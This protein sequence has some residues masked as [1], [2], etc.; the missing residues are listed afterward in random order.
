MSERPRHDPDRSPLGFDTA[1]EE[2]SLD[3]ALT[4]WGRAER[5]RGVDDGLVERV[6]VASVPAIAARQAS[7]SRRPD[8][9][10]SGPATSRS[11]W[12]SATPARLALAAGVLVALLLPATLDLETPSGSVSD[13]AAVSV[14][15]EEVAE[16]I[17]GTS[18]SEPLLLAFIEPDTASWEDVAGHE[19]GTDLYALLESGRAGLDDYL[20]ELDAILGTLDGAGEGM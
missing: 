18:T 11:R 20:L 8:A 7:I 2:R 13:A 9:A 3:A 1:S 12:W 6:F 10:R 19:S 16:P 14:A 15:M 5:L 17:G 4:A